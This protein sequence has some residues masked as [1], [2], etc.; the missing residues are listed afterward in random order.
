MGGKGIGGA[1]VI[2]VVSNRRRSNRLPG[3]WNRSRGSSRNSMRRREAGVAV[4][5]CE[6]AVF[7]SLSVGRE[8][9]SYRLSLYTPL[10]LSPSSSRESYNFTDCVP[11]S[12]PLPSLLPLTT[13]TTTRQEETTWRCVS[14]PPIPTV[15]HSVFGHWSTS[16]EETAPLASSSSSSSLFSHHPF[17][18][19][20]LCD[21]LNQ[22]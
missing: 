15:L 3:K 14:V 6:A 1:V 20:F 9:I 2:V 11:S 21:Q 13:T 10:S 22:Q 4:V 18:S 5:Y 19:L 8:I 7:F 17:P 12:F 16:A